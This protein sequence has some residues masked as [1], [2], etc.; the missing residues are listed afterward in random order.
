MV[1]LLL[2]AICLSAVPL[3]GAADP[4][5]TQTN[6]IPAAI[7]VAMT[8]LRIHFSLFCPLDPP[9]GRAVVGRSKRCQVNAESPHRLVF[10]AIQAP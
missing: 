5:D 10:A 2:V 9:R 4:A 8:I 3:T 6:P 1:A 7:N